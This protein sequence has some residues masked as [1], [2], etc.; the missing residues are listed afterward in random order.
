[1]ALI[2]VLPIPL[3]NV[4][5]ALATMFI[6]LGLAFRDGVAIVL[7]FATAGLALLF[8]AALAGMVWVWG[9]DWA[10]RWVLP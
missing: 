8:T 6:G 3:G 9:G 5:P 10:M 4:L 1:M 7:S 2:V